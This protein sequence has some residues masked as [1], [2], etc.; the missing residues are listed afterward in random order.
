MLMRD[1]LAFCSW[2]AQSK[3]DSVCSVARLLSQF[4]SGSP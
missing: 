2:L 3:E 1:L 4:A